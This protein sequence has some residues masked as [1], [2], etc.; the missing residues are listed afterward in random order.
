MMALV[1][2]LTIP[3]Y[4]SAQGGGGG[5]GQAKGG[6]GKGGGATLG[7]ELLRGK[8]IPAGTRLS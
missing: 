1:L 2:S 4:I 7:A 8:G 3:A 5:G 6:G